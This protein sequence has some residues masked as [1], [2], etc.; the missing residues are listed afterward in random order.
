MGWRIHFFSFFACL[1]VESQKNDALREVP[2]A[3]PLANV[4]NKKEK[5]K[6][7]KE[8]KEKKEGEK[9]KKE[10]KEKRKLE[11]ESLQAG[12]HTEVYCCLACYAPRQN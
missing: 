10:K 6:D 11:G 1:Q 2:S 3:G 4:D 5:T 7:K 9:T 12:K 8:R